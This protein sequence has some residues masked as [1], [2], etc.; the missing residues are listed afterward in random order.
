M[1]LEAKILTFYVL[2]SATLIVWILHPKTIKPIPGVLPND[3]IEQVIVDPIKHQLIITTKAGTTRQ[4]LPDRQ[5]LFDIKTDGTVKITA[6]QFGYEARPFIGI[7]ISQGVR[8]YLGANLF[9]FKKLDLGLGIGFPPLSRSNWQTKD[10]KPVL[11]IGY[12]VYD[13]T[14]INF[15]YDTSKMYHAFLSVRL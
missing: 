3:D 1:K 12:N 6:S 5:T 7:G 11:Q 15:G 4:T 8:I 2:L 14:S 10:I 9:Y 13:N